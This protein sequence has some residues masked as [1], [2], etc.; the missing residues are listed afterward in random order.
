MTV[1]GAEFRR[2]NTK[3]T[4]T[5]DVEWGST[6]Y[7][8]GKVI[9]PDREFLEYLIAEGLVEEYGNKKHGEQKPD[10]RTRTFDNNKS[11]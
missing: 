5:Q 1:Q 6:T 3:V 11:E 8:A 7:P 9:R 4:L 10:I 2:K